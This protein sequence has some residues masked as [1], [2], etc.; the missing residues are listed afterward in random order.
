MLSA[1][2]WAVIGL[3][4]KVAFV[5]ML[6]L[7]IPAIA[8]AWLLARRSFPG[9]T[10]V[11]ALVHLPLVLPPVVT[12]YVLLVILGRRGIIGNWLYETWGISIA[13][14]WKGAAIAAAVMAFPLMVR[15]VRL[16]MEMSDPRLEIVARSLGAGPWRVLLTVTLPLALPGIISGWVLA[17]ARS[18]GEFGATMTLAGNIP[19]E[20]RTLPVAIYALLQMPDGDQRAQRLVLITIAIALGALLTAAWVQRRWQ[21]ARGPGQVGQGEGFGL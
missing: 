2:E 10:L 7:T 14:T 8:V 15:S 17:F 13:F 6:I 18:L 12:G 9:K 16:A 3:S 1:E 11:D 5:A 20:S 19:G 21:R 4:A